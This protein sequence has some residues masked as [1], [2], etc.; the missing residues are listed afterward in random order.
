MS[1]QFNNLIN[2]L[3]K[4]EKIETGENTHGSI[5]QMREN[6]F[7]EILEKY[8]NLNNVCLQEEKRRRF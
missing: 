8:I 1:N 5:K 4:E 3:K 2:T 6:I 7:R